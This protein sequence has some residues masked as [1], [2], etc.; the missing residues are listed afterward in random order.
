MST[1]DNFRA[2][3]NELMNRQAAEQLEAQRQQDERRER[4]AKMPR[5]LRYPAAVWYELTRAPT[6]A[7]I[8]VWLTGVITGVAITLIF[9]HNKIH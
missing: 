7:A 3:I 5:G 4:I 8:V 9:V 2:D 1:P 6:S